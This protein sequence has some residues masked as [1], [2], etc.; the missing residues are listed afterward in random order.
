[1]TTHFGHIYSNANLVLTRFFNSTPAV[2]F[3]LDG[4]QS[5]RRYLHVTFKQDQ[6][7]RF[8][9]ARIGFRPGPGEIVIERK[10]VNFSSAA[11]PPAHPDSPVL[12]EAGNKSAGLVTVDI[13]WL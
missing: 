6:P 12:S 7:I 11:Q 9:E 3:D 4:R 8:V 2:E 10:C 13:P 5:G 1:M